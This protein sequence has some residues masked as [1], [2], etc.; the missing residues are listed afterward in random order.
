MAACQEGSDC[1]RR[2]MSPVDSVL[3]P[4]DK[5][6]RVDPVDCLGV[7]ADLDQYRE[8][9]PTYGPS[10]Q[11]AEERS[12]PCDNWSAQIDENGLP[13]YPTYKGMLRCQTVAERV[14]TVR[15]KTAHHTAELVESRK[16]FW[17]SQHVVRD[18][19]ARHPDV[20]DAATTNAAYRLSQCHRRRIRE[21]F[22]RYKVFHGPAIATYHRPARSG[23]HFAPVPRAHGFLLFSM[24]PL[25]R[26]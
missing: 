15:A 14:A 13:E 18:S 25:V 1:W 2:C 21:A 6:S 11:S 7:W 20:T 8:P 4:C 26:P 24:L 16:Y 22:H 17:R 19:T 5:P 3:R 23:C 10:P 12:P 9:V